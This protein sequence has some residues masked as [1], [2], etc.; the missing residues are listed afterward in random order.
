MIKNY[1]LFYSY[2][3]IGDVLLIDFGSAL[4]A[5]HYKRIDDLTIIYHHDLVIGYNIFNILRIVKIRNNGL[6]FLPSKPLVDIINNILLNYHLET[7]EY[8]K[9]SGYY[10]GEIINIIDCDNYKGIYIRCSSNVYFSLLEDRHVEIGDK[11]VI[12]LDGSLLNN[13]SVFRK[14]NSNYGFI[15]CHV[16][17]NKELNIVNDDDVFLADKEINVGMDFFSVEEAIN[18]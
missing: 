6:I 10:T 17:T 15:N 7:L 4:K 18:E 2:K 13:G 5:T 8:K 1:S 3:S 9:M 14:K 12:V 16:C 11:V